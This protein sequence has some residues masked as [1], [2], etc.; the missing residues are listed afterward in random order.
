MRRIAHLADIAAQQRARQRG[1]AHVGVRHQAELQA[2]RC[3]AHKATLRLVEAA[4]V[5]R[6]RVVHGGGRSAL[7]TNRPTGAVGNPCSTPALRFVLTCSRR[8]TEGIHRLP[9]PC[10]DC[11]RRLPVEGPHETRGLQGAGRPRRAPRCCAT[12]TQLERQFMS[13]PPRLPTRAVIAGC[14]TAACAAAGA[15]CRRSRACPTGAASRP[16]AYAATRR[17]RR[18]R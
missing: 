17:R 3:V 2:V 5:L 11:P 4:R 7:A 18:I 16:A 12:P 15:R 10:S 14:R 9:C 1:L 6:C 13:F 8:T